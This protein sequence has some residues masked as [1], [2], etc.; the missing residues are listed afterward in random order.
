MRRME[1]PTRGRG[2]LRRTR[3]RPGRVGSGRVGSGRV[4]SGR[5]G[6]AQF[7]KSSI[8]SSSRFLVSGTNFT[9]NPM[10]SRATAA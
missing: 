6:S 9:T 3:T 1:R 4:G 10:D 2:A 8:C 5:V 7:E